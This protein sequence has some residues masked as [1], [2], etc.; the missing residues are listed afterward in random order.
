MQIQVLIHKIIS[1]ALNR[2]VV[3]YD[4]PE[5]PG[6]GHVGGAAAEPAELWHICVFIVRRGG[7]KGGR[8]LNSIY[9]SVVFRKEREIEF[10]KRCERKGASEGEVRSRLGHQRGHG[11][12]GARG[13]GAAGTEKLCA[14]STEQSTAGRDCQLLSVPSSPEPAERCVLREV[15][16]ACV[17]VLGC[18]RA[19]TGVGC[20]SVL[21]CRFAHGVTPTWLRRCVCATHQCVATLLG[22]GNGEMS[23]NGR[24]GEQRR[25]GHG[26]REQHPV[27][28]RQSTFL[29]V[30]QRYSKHSV[31]Q[32]LGL[33]FRVLKRLFCCLPVS[34]GSLE[35][36]H[37]GS[38][39]PRPCVPHCIP[40]IS[41][42]LP[43]CSPQPVG[44][45]MAGP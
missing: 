1:G 4:L 24:W 19:L 10:M 16:S 27:R 38:P 15:R 41:W 5:R 8:R 32:Q 7:G 13:R 42:L 14:P 37:R 35:L 34:V 11:L 20:R 43:L 31:P 22:M 26:P 40:P 29:S 33:S 36:T 45:L 9:S 3:C 44:R 30:S 18:T 23:C 6:A 2:K 12:G 39:T 25:A 28:P 21:L 17:T